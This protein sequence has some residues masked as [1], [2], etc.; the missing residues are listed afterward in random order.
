MLVSP[1]SIPDQQ[2]L[3]TDVCIIGAGPAGLAAAQELLDSGLDVILLESGG[4][5]PDTATQQLAAGVSED[6]PD[7]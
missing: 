7:L 4:E 1:H 5:E 2:T 3:N 6:T